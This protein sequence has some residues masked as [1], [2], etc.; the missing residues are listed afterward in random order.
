MVT[1]S[2]ENIERRGHAVAAEARMTKPEIRINAEIR[3]TSLW[4]PDSGFGIRN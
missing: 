3:M 1:G 4:S 2:F